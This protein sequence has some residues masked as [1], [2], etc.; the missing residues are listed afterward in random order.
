MEDKVSV[1]VG[2]IPWK[3]NEEGLREF[4]EENEISPIACRVVIDRGLNRSK[5]YGYCDFS[6][7]EE[8]DKLL[9]LNGTYMDDGDK[10][11]RA[12]KCDLSNSERGGRRENRGRGRGAGNSYGGSSDGGYGRGDGGY[13]RGGRGGR[14]GGGFGQQ[15]QSREQQNETP[16]KLLMVRNLSYDTETQTLQD[17]FPDAIDARVVW[18]RQNDRSKGFGFVEFDDVDAA[19]KAREEN[20]GVE[21]DGRAMMI[22]FATPR[23]PG[24]D[25][26]RRGGFNN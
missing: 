2:N 18:D 8:A 5:G 26:Q 1:F 22:I 11:K 19:T 13:G 10:P 14:G 6:T 23:A 12:I 20:N 16:T 7:Q 9:A 21:L 15:R 4:C 17:H 25:G 24:G 3:L